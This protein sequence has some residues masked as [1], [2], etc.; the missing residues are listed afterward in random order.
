MTAAT[1]VATPPL[2]ERALLAALNISEWRGRRRDREVTDRVARDHG[3]DR[4]AGCYTKALVPKTF[5]A[6]IATVR[7]EARACHH[8]LTL[9]WC[10]DGFR[11]LPVDLH[12]DYM[13]RFR[14]LRS[15][16]HEAVAG[17]IAAYD[18]A[19]AA[20]RSTLGSLYRETDYPSSDSLRRAFELEVKL[21]PLPAAHDW[22][23]DLPETTLGRIRLDLETRLVDAQRLAMAD[24]YRRLAAVVSRMATTVAQPDRIFRNSLVGNVRELCTLLPSL[25]LARDEDLAALGREVESRLGGLA[26]ARLRQDPVVRQD[27]AVAAEALLETINA[28]LASYTGAA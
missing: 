26:P 10:D 5:L 16:Y 21:Q 11:I 2:T 9:P 24:L 3:A 17:F 12:L 1:S 23:I 25:N 8:Q 19:K 4:R 6:A 15:R 14:A 20:A 7:N 28:R 27:A 18:E 22:R 13:E